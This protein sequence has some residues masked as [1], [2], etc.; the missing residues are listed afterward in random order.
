M[1]VSVDKTAIRDAAS[2]IVLRDRLTRP[3]ILMGQRGAEAAFMPM[4]F[5][6]PGGAVDVGDAAVPLARPL[7][8]PCDARLA[9][10]SGRVLENPDLLKHVL[11]RQ[12]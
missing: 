1:G 12:E 7:P 2:I 10:G 6:F 4:K 9:M 3:A 5:V 8:S 11:F